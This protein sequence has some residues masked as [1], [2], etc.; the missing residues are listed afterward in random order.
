MLGVNAKVNVNLKVK[1][2]KGFVFLCRYCR[3]TLIGTYKLPEFYQKAV[4][5]ARFMSV[6]C[7]DRFD[8][9]LSSKNC[10]KNARLIGSLPVN[11]AVEE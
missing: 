10:S 8:G 3:C 6:F 11:L 9:K 7:F 5:A 2:Q 4:I 1:Q